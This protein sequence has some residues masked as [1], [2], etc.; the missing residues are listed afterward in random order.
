AAG[1]RGRLRKKGSP[2]AH[3]DQAQPPPS[4]LL[5]TRLHDKVSDRGQGGDLSGSSLSRP[6]AQ[7]VEMGLQFVLDRDE[8]RYS[9][10]VRKRIGHRVYCTRGFST[11]SKSDGARLLLIRPRCAVANQQSSGTTGR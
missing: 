5:L 8:I 3:R 7:L 6:M 11:K 4:T 9:R 2:P 10:K 1:R